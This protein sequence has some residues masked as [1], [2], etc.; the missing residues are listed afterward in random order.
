MAVEIHQAVAIEVSRD[1][2]ESGRRGTGQAGP[3]GDILKRAVPEVAKQAI[4]LRR[5]GEG[6]AVVQRSVGQKAAAMSSDQESVVVTDVEV[7]PS[8]AIEVEED[9]RHAPPPVVHACFE[10]HVDEGPIAVV[11]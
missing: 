4:F 2:P 11:S 8:V 7:E 10:G 9:R 6:P 5:P 3:S 1:S